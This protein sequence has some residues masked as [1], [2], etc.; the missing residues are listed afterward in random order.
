MPE[1][2]REE[3]LAAATTNLTRR[4]ENLIAVVQTN[5][6]AVERLQ[7]EVNQ[8]PDDSEMQFIA[9]LAKSQRRR[10]LTYAITTG[11]VSAVLSGIVAFGA[12]TVVSS[13]QI[14]KSN[15]IGFEECIATNQRAIINAVAF[16]DVVK[17]APVENTIVKQIKRA[18]TE[19]EESVRDCNKLY[20][21]DE[22]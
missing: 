16:R 19:L 8:K 12:A 1:K 21:E 5:N 9:G 6:K 3:N 11:V 18:A 4:V 17:G 14:R 13:A 15:Q 10:Y 20:P 22:R 2:S 7:H